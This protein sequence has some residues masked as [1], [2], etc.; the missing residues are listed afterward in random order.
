VT[1]RAWKILA[2]GVAIAGIGGF[3][4]AEDRTSP[5]IKTAANWG[6]YSSEQ[7]NAVTTSFARRGFV[8][9]SVRVVTGTGL[10]DGHPFALIGSRSN[11]GGE[12]F[13]VA[14]GVTLG[15]TVCRIS[16]PVTVFYASDMCAACS[17]GGSPANTHS[18]LA[19]VRGDVT[20]TMIYQGRES[21][22]GV[23]PAGTGFAFNSSFGRSDRLRARDASGRVLASISPPA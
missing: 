8:R 7:W 3:A 2:V 6:L 1:L 21:G 9:N 15:R 12:C 20:V 22:V 11:V 18:I 17:P 19:L 14:R 13:A 4:A 23:V 16:K 5:S 10:A